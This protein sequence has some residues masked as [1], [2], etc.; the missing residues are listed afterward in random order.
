M[1][2]A[3]RAK[4]AGREFGSKLKRAGMLTNSSAFGRIAA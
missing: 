4:D 3:A 2:P 1:S